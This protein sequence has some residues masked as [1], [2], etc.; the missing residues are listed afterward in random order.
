MKKIVIVLGSVII[1]LALAAS[2][3]VIYTL[4][5]QTPVGITDQTSNI[6][7]I[8]ARP[9]DWRQIAGQPVI[10][11][12][13]M[14]IIDGSTA[15]VPI[16]AELLR[17]FY[18]YTDDQVSTS[19]FVYHSTTDTAYTYLADR[20]PRIS[21]S[22]EPVSLILVT[23]PSDD[24][25]RYAESHGVELD[26]TPIAKDGFVFITHKDNPIDSLTVEQ[27]Q[28]IYSGDITN[29]SQVGGENLD[30]Q[31]YQREKDSGSQTAME[32]MVM[33]GLSMK[34]PL[35]TEI[36]Y[37]MGV[38]VDAV[39]EYENGP[40]SI[41]YTYNYYINNLYKNDNIKVIEIEGVTPTD[42]NF[43]NDTYPFT[44]SYYAVIRGDE[45]PDSPAR[46][47]RDWLITPLG[48]DVIEL[49][50]YCKAVN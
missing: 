34:P 8:L 5:N 29:W 2:G 40:A 22:S 20:E 13:A 46:Q 6:N 24:E 11:E 44:T 15:T 21:D 7:V 19:E 12:Q 31:A 42:E 27:I 37:G 30:I 18:G 49:A 38:L 41:G 33:R 16:T 3:L 9:A 35:E 28:G 26:L 39:A 47:L 43:I 10:D 25:E 36:A 14:A 32:E 1:A 17:Q 4:L 23:P 48:Q 50:G 45:P